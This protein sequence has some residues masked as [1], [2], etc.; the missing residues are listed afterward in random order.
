MFPQYV[1]GKY[2][3]VGGMEKIRAQAIK[4]A[5]GDAELSAILEV[6]PLFRW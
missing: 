2:T 1:V 4:K 3:Y 5:E 6:I